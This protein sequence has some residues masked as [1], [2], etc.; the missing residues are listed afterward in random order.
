MMIDI[1]ILLVRWANYS[2]ETPQAVPM[3][4]NDFEI[5][6]LEE[7]L[8]RLQVDARILQNENDTYKETLASIKTDKGNMILS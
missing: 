8:Q 1:I 4:N 3:P 2:P 7:Q 6:Q 5:T